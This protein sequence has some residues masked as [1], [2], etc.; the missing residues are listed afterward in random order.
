[1]KRIGTISYNIYCNFT[2]YGSA[3]QTWA[4]HQAIKKLGHMPVLV[5][6]CPDVLADKDPLNPFGNMWD[7]D[8]E[9]RRMVE[10]TMPAIRANYDKFDN[11]YHQRFDR[12]SVKYNS[13]NFCDIVAEKLDGFVCG[14]DTIFCIDEFKGF[15]DG[16]YANY[17]EMKRNSVSYAAS[18]GDSTFDSAS[19][20]VLNQ[21]LTNF[22]AIGI[23]E[24]AML[25]YVREHTSVPVS[26]TIDPT[27]LLTL[28]DYDRLAS[29][30]QTNNPYLLLYARRYDPKMEQYAEKIANERGLKIV[31]IS[32]RAANAE[33]GHIMRY[34]AGVEEFLSLVKHSSFVVTNSFHGLIFAVQYSRPMVVFTREQADSKINEVL[35][36][37]DVMHNKL[38]TGSEC[39]HEIDYEAVHKNIAKARETSFDFLQMELGLL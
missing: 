20:G 27:L 13:Q 26:R 10:L 39:Y 33:K 18:F 6:Y 29:E 11:F 32:L 28:T 5:D 8:E 24:N 16:Y 21:R 4:L 36:L 22:K 17:P 38:S 15:E 19:F 12:T 14:S 31:E 23:R 3:L 37:F 9:S 7:Q 2:N 1:M 30:R 35:E 25:D 34:D